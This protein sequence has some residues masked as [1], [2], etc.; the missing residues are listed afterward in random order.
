MAFFFFFFRRPCAARPTKAEAN[1]ANL[2]NAQGPVYMGYTHR[3][4]QSRPPSV[5]DRTHVFFFS[6]CRIKGKASQ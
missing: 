1:P 4:P 6:F 3:G 2:H 5:S